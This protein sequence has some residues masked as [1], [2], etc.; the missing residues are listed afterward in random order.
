MVTLV[1]GAEGGHSLFGA[2]RVLTCKCSFVHT[3]HGAQEAA[4]AHRATTGRWP[5]LQPRRWADLGPF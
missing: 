2:D 3:V 5:R 4:I 1:G